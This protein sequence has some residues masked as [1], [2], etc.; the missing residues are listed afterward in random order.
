M[1]PKV[2][3]ELNQFVNLINK[4]TGITNSFDYNHCIDMFDSFVSSNTLFDP[5]EI[6]VWLITKAGLLP[7]DAKVIEAMAQK[8]QDGRRVRRRP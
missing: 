4:K 3:E 7:Q 2:E 8:F 1:E 5:G 6:R